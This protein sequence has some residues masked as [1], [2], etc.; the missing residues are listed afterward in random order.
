RSPS[1][2]NGVHKLSRMVDHNQFVW[3]DK[4]WQAPPLAAA[5]I[6]ELHLGTFT[7]KG[8]FL[9]AIEKLDHL[10]TLGITHVELMPVV[11]FSGDHGW[12]Y[13][14]VDLFA[15]HHAYGEPDDLK[16]LVDA[17]HARGLA[18]SLGA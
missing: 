13:D 7:A 6:Y 2:P 3:T 18:G 1:Q 5:L 4:T 12:G 8:T 9:S 10:V 14:G 11:E 15:P 16:K 17:C